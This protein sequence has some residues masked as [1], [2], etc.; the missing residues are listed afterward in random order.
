MHM[1]RT[2]FLLRLVTIGDGVLDDSS[3]SPLRI[4]FDA[5]HATKFLTITGVAT[6]T[7]FLYLNF[8]SLGGMIKV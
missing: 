5:D 2:Y 1:R 4:R 6:I 7:L 8:V 3:E